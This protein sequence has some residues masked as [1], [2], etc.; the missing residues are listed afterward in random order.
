MSDN[1]ELS[2]RADLTKLLQELGALNKT[3][4]TVA[5]NM[6]RMGDDLDKNIQRNTKKTEKH[7]EALRD[8][9]RRIADQLRGYFKSLADEA[10]IVFKGLQKDLGLKQQFKEAT[11]GAI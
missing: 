4:L 10:G 2:V 3:A 7:F 9:G 6:K 5:D 8:L 11:T 1:V